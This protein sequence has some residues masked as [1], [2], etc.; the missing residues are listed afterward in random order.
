MKIGYARVSTE[1]QSL[2]MQQ[3][4]LTAAGCE[5]V[6]SDLV[7][8]TKEDRP[9]LNQ[10]LDHLGAFVSLNGAARYGHEPS[11]DRIV[12]TRSETASEA[13]LPEIITTAAGDQ[14]RLFG[15]AEAALWSIEVVV[16]RA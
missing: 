12:L 15:V 3:D 14:V 1:D 10:A 8:G 16:N 4:A 2:D 7:S 13:D 6:F 9:G 5:R 11:A